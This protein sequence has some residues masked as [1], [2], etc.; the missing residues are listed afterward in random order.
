M[1]DQGSQGSGEVGDKMKAATQPGDSKTTTQKLS[2]SV[3]QGVQTVKQS[4][5]S[6]VESAKDAAPKA[7]E[8]AS[9]TLGGGGK[10]IVC[11]VLDFY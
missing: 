1:A 11:K 6:A 7:S 4:A 9:E 3:Q 10:S 2:E 8:T 5:G